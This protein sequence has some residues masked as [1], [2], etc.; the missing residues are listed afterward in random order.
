MGPLPQPKGDAAAGLFAF[1][2][3]RMLTTT[4]YFW[5]KV[6]VLTCTPITV[7]LWRR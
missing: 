4:I 5:G 1:P 3:G 6:I 2:R 7:P